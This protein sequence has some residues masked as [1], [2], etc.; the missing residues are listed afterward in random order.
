LNKF[1]SLSFAS[2]FNGIA[3]DYAELISIKQNEFYNING[4]TGTSTVVYATNSS[5]INAI[6]N[7]VRKCD[8]GSLTSGS[9]VS[10]Y[11]ISV[12]CKTN[13]VNIIQ[14]NVI[15]SVVAAIE[16]Y[17]FAALYDGSWLI[18]RNSITNNN[19]I[20]PSSSFYGTFFYG[21][22]NLSIKSNLIANNNSNTDNYS[23]WNVNYKTGLILDIRQNTI[24]TRENNSNLNT[25][26][27]YVEDD[28]SI[29]F[30]GNI[31]DMKGAGN[32]TPAFLY[33]NTAIKL[34]NNNSFNI[35]YSGSQY[36]NLGTNSFSNFS[37]WKSSS[38]V[39]PGESFL[40]PVFVNVAKND[41]RS[42]CFETQYFFTFIG[43]V[44]R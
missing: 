16:M 37:G 42:N 33:S 9:L 8:F 30:V 38:D 26:G 44:P 11:Y 40:N 24:Y 32:G 22:E 28:A 7:K 36:W 27:F 18:D 14:S 21:L 29:T 15:D 17:G 20:A 6:G 13:S 39:G 31:I 1:S 12:A 5:D 23:L 25:Y 35:S 3:I 2:Y 4:L 41:F 19:A 34:C 10:Y 43:K